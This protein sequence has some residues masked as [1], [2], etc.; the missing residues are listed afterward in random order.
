MKQAP[1]IKVLAA[2][3]AAV[4]VAGVGA[5]FYQYSSMCEVGTRVDTLRKKADHEKELAKQAEASAQKVKETSEQLAHLEKGVP[6]PAYVPTLLKELEAVGTKN[7]ISVL[8]VRP[9]ITVDPTKKDDPNSKKKKPYDELR[10]EVKGRGTYRSVM[11]FLG[12]L[13]E[14]PKIVAARSLTAS[15]KIETGKASTGQLDVTIELKT[16]LFVESKSDAAK[17]K[18]SKPEPEVTVKN[19]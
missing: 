1:N 7:G 9:M 17:S 6:K 16:Y 5:T 12:A 2:V 8:G 3:T 18:A 15:P 14:F 19:G 4:F 10:I 13:K 11:N